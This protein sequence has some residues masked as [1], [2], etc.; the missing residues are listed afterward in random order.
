[1]PDV[2]G[3][4]LFL[5]YWRRPVWSS[6]VDYGDDLRFRWRF[7]RLEDRYEA[8]IAEVQGKGEVDQGW[9]KVGAID[10]IVDAGPPVRV[11]F[12]QDGGILDNWEGVVYDPSGSVLL[13]RQFKRDWSNW[14]DPALLHVK[15][16][17]GGDLV[18][19]RPI[20]GHFYRCWFT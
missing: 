17:F 13:A 3:Y 7:A 15:K 19:C 5:V 11:A 2:H 18:Y 1:L 10:Y 6:L 16:L 8:I 4:A 20:K 9:R 14:H 12:R